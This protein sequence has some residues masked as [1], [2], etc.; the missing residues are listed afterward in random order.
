MKTSI[1]NKILKVT[2]SGLLL[3]TL[4]V[5]GMGIYS[6]NSFAQKHSKEH[7]QSISEKETVKISAKLSSIEQYVKTLNFSVQE[8][9]TSLSVLTDSSSLENFTNQNLN[10]IRSTIK[11]VPNAVAVYLRYNPKLTPPTSGI[12]MAKTSLKSGIRK[13]T[14][15]DFSKYDPNDVEHVGWYYIPVQSGKPIW[16]EPYKNLNIDV[17]MISYV[18]PIFRFGEEIGVVGVDVDFDYL[19]QEIRKIKLFDTGYAYLED[20]KGKVV[21]HP[22][23]PYGSDIKQ[24][25]D[26]EFVR[27]DLPNGMKL[28]LVVP[29][30]EIFKDRNA[31]I[32]NITLFT[33]FIL[34]VF[35][36]IVSFISKSITRP[37]HLLTKAANQMTNGNL[38]VSFDTSSDDEV[39]ELS[40]SFSNAKQ[41]IKEYLDYIQGVAYKDALTS[42][43][44]NTSYNNYIKELQ[45]KIDSGMVKEFGL[46]VLDVNH[47]KKVND[48]Y[49]HEKGN[50]LLI[51]ASRLVCSIFEHSPVFRLGGDEFAVI[52]TN[53]DYQIRDKLIQKL[54][55]SMK[56]LESKEQPW[57]Q[58]SIACGLSIFDSTTDTSVGDV[59]KRA[60]DA[61]YSD[62]KEMKVSRI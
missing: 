15:T 8:E 52:L 9:L 48:F 5:G 36:L 27:S 60:D 41:Y 11:Y 58:V 13:Q 45:E 38:D 24:N 35:S 34:L 10:F 56:V 29:R 44:N 19:T 1:K 32:L 43:R 30:S 16:M 57:E 20:S 51:N 49:G 26:F 33:I 53:G 46:A 37:L 54:K 55:T 59:F 40:R 22:T 50:A 28:I 12:F 21:Y 17:Y 2:L 39:G 14:P 25:Q 47:L 62:K 23:A 18:V 7:L 61:M 31:L 3:S 4:L 6:A 42:L